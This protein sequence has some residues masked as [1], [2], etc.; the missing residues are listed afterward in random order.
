LRCG[1]Q[2]SGVGCAG[3]RDVVI[4]PTK[5]GFVFFVLDRDEPVWPVD[6]RKVPQGAV[7]GEQLSP[8]QPFSD[9]R[10]AAADTT[11]QIRR[12]VQAAIA[13]Q[14]LMRGVTRTPAQ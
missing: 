13:R 9:P 5:Q 11:F 1:Q 3:I 14:R 8:T 7:E 12:P 4:Q 6:E 10:A 2:A